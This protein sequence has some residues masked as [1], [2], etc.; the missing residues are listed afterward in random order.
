MAHTVI[1][2]A[3]VRYGALDLALRERV[4]VI[5][6]RRLRGALM[7]LENPDGYKAAIEQMRTRKLGLTS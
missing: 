4:E 2:M 3:Q 5:L 6:E 7:A 1:Q